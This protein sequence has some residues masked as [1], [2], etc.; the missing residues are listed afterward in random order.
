MPDEALTKD[1][2]M[3]PGKPWTREELLLVM[4]LYCRI[5]FGRQ[6]SHA[7][8]VIDLAAALGRTPGSVAMKLNNFSSLDPA[9]A[10]RGIRGLPGVS[11]ADREV[12]DAF[13]ADWE[14]YSA[15]SQRL[16]ENMVSQAAIVTP[17]PELA[18]AKDQREAGIG[19]EAQ[20]IFDG[21]TEGQAVVTVRRAQGFFRRAVLAA[22]VCRCCV[23]DNPVP[24]LL[25]ASHILPWSRYSEHRTN[26]HNGLCLSRL[27]DAA[28]DRGLM[29][30]DEQCRVVLSPL[31][32]SYLPSQT[33]R[34]N[35]I[36]YEGKVIRPPQKLAP[37]TKFLQIHREEVFHG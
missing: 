7:F 23:S 25:V 32:R 13:H 31:L 21:L 8:E 14:T 22:Y 1:I 4:N 10:V 11:K 5:P 28:F 3:R 30:L 37:D 2:A 17:L 19:D 26:P 27:H 34:E 15:E 35:F 29:T 33:L 20:P 36:Q 16:W 24:E 12:W 9:E 18:E 6:H